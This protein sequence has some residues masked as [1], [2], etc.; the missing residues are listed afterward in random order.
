[1]SNINVAQNLQG[2]STSPP[3]PPGTHRLLPFIE[4]FFVLCEAGV[5]M[6]IKVGPKKACEYVYITIYLC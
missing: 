5:L 2:S 6:K 3:L 4:A 1:M